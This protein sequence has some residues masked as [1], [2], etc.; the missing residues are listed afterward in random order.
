MPQK[1]MGRPPSENPLHERIYLRVDKE[2][3][4]MLDKC[5]DTLKTTRSEI[6]R[7]G[8]KKVHDD[9]EEK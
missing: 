9:L 6:V 2:T 4:M 1:K 7:Q 3:K 5:T 8:I